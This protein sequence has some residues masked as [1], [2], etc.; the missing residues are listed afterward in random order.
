[1]LR[2]R[3]SEFGRVLPW[4]V[5]AKAPCDSADRWLCSVAL[6]GTEK[7]IMCHP[8][9]QSARDLKTRFPNGFMFGCLGD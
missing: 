3:G 9:R 5:S 4:A 2:V 6:E 7:L 1:V 8:R